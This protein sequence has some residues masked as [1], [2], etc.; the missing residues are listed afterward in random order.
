MA[1][2]VDWQLGIENTALNAELLKEQLQA[3]TAIDIGNEYDAL[4]LD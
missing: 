4:A 3:V 1:A 2:R